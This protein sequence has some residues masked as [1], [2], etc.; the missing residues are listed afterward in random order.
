MLHTIERRR[1]DPHRICGEI[2]AES[3]ALV[4][5]HFSRK[6]F[7]LNE[8]C[9]TVE[10]RLVENQEVDKAEIKKVVQRTNGTRSRNRGL[11]IV[12]DRI[13]CGIWN[14]PPE[15]TD[16]LGRVLAQWA[17]VEFVLMAPGDRI[18]AE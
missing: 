6:A 16:W 18:V 15:V 12:T 9:L 5:I 11:Y 13:K 3:E 10:S 8:H 7:R 14:Q 2:V 17:G 4:L 1:I